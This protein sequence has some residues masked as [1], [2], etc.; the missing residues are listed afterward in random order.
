MVIIKPQKPLSVITSLV[1]ILLL[2]ILIFVYL[3]VVVFGARVVYYVVRS[4]V[5]KL[6]N[7]R[8]VEFSSKESNR[9][10]V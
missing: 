5:I 8:F 2:C 3:L 7:Q 1:F 9:G 4:W 6:Y 10:L